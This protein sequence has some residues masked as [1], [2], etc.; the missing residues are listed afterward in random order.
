MWVHC[1][2]M[3]NNCLPFSPTSHNL[4]DSE[5]AAKKV[6]HLKFWCFL[7]FF[8]FPDLLHSVNIVWVNHQWAKSTCAG[9]PGSSSEIPAESALIITVSPL[10]SEDREQQLGGEERSSP[11]SSTDCRR[12]SRR[13][14]LWILT[15]IVMNSCQRCPTACAWIWVLPHES[16]ASL[17]AVFVC[18]SPWRG[19]LF[20]WMCLC[21]ASV[22]RHNE[23]RVLFEGCSVVGAQRAKVH[24][25][26]KCYLKVL[27]G[28]KSIFANYLYK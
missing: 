16:R 19:P 10:P 24:V 28:S 23:R 17:G 6:E 1:Y 4:I 21:P 25:G 11:L 15:S 26:Y 22:E 12:L 9:T 3:Q 8:Y 5:E 14:L 2:T 13:V 7:L 20:L 27:Y 18:A